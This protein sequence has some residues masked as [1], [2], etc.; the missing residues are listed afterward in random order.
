MGKM[1]QYDGTGPLKRGRVIR[2]GRGPCKT[3]DGGCRSKPS[4]RFRTLNEEKRAI[5]GE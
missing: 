2:R 1:P 4:P 3:G 5:D